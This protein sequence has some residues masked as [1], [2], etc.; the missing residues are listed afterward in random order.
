MRKLKTSELNRL[1][2]EEF[3]QAHKIP[4]VVVL[5]NVRSMYNVGSVFRTCDA[6]AVERLFLCGITPRPP[7]REIHKTAIGATDSMDWTYHNSVAEAITSLKSDGYFIIGLEQTDQSLPIEDFVLDFKKAALILGHEVTGISD[8]VL[9]L[10]D[11]SLEI[12]QSGTKHSLN[13][14]VAAGIAIYQ[15]AKGL[16]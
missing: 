4:L 1:S 3:K 9:G 6:F 2:I 10:L 8:E 14:S 11:I 15:L 13:V 5:D 12:Q 16:R 7:H